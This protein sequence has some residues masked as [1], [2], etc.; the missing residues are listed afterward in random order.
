M[1]V[2][3]SASPDMP[4]IEGL[5]VLQLGDN[6][7]HLKL[8]GRDGWGRAFCAGLQRAIDG[9]YD[10]AV[11]IETDLLFARPVA[12]VIGKMGSVGV[13][14]AA[15]LELSVALGSLETGAY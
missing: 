9:R 2:V 1:L 14:V 5:E 15:P 4:S 3:D 12:D 11:H 6:I 13:D 7:G 10:W 8:T